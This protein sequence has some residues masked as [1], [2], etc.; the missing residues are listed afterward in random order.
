MD[1]FKIPGGINK[2]GEVVLAND[3]KKG[4]SYTCISCSGE[5]IFRVG[6]IREKHFSHAPNNSCSSETIMH[7]LA[8]R[9]IV[10]AIEQ[11]AEGKNDI[12]MV[13]KCPGCYNEFMVE[14]PRST[15]SKAEEEVP[16]SGFI[17][18]AIAYRDNKD[19]LGIEIFQTHKVDEYKGSNL[20]IPW[21][22]F[23]AID[24]IKNPYYWHPINSN[25]LN[26]IKCKQCK[27]RNQN[28]INVARKWGIDSNIFTTVKNPESGNY[29]ADVVKCFH[30][31]NEIPVFWWFGIPFSQDKP[32]M[33]MPSTIKY[34]YSKYLRISCYMNT[35]PNCNV[36]QDDYYLFL[37]NDGPF[38]GLP[39]I[40]NDNPKYNKNG[41]TAFMFAA[42]K[43]LGLNRPY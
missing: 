33:P 1:Y 4:E 42:Y 29:I 23:N 17:C 2:L 14:I 37:D 28:I 20:P 39:M 34:K 22:E 12:L 27:K 36:P 18:D 16:I 19:P 6:E 25:K 5:L 26:P 8:K 40:M 11:N 3:A 7:L 21:V 9:R 41:R 32:P 31:E 10:K 24:I 15:F 35:C 43:F 38:S 30:C 13:N